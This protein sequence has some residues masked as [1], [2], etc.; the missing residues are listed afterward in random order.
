MSSTLAALVSHVCFYWAAHQREVHCL[1]LAWL[2]LAGLG[3]AWLG[4]AWLG[5][6]FFGLAFFGLALAWLL[7]ATGG[8]RYNRSWKTLYNRNR[9]PGAGAGNDYAIQLASKEA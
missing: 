9:R 7:P 4:L 1:G 6:A 8:P 2:G 3:W 5:L